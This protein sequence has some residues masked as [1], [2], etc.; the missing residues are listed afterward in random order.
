MFLQHSQSYIDVLLMLTVS[1]TVSHLYQ[2]RIEF[3]HEPEKKC[4][5][6]ISGHPYHQEGGRIHQTTGL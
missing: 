2:N 3:T 1:M 6:H 5:D 4:P